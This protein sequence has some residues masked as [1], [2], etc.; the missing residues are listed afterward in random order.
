MTKAIKIRKVGNSHGLTLPKET[1]TKLRVAE[2]D[3]LYVTFTPE[4]LLLSPY[5]P[6]VAEEVEAFRKSYA[7]YRDVYHELA[8]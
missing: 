3:T 1:L 8:K 5:D 4:G 6:A 2:G 7:A